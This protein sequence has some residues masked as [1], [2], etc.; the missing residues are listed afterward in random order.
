[1]NWSV[2]LPG[3]MNK[4]GHSPA[5]GLST[6][7]IGCVLYLPG[8]PGGGN[9]IYDRSPYGNI[10][11]ITGAVW[12]RLPSGLWYL[13]FDGSDDY[14]ATPYYPDD[15]AKTFMYWLNCRAISG[16]YA[17]GVNDGSNHRFYAGIDKDGNCF[18][19]MGDSSK[20]TVASGI[21]ADNWYLISITGDGL[22]ARYYVNAIE[23]DNFS[24]SQSGDSIEPFY[25]GV[26]KTLAGVTAKING[27]VALPRVCNRVLSPLEIQNHFNREKHLFGVW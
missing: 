15:S 11:T 13:D 5:I 21:T 9:K 20:Y 4:I 26:L 2:N 14:V 17:C 7:P 18:F 3:W 16:D 22:T 12:K 23:K 25:V 1:M 10:G 27:L 6:P 8:V 24:Y 19:G